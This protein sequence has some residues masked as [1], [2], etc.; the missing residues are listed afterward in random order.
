MTSLT[1][2][3][4]SARTASSSVTPAPEA[5]V[6]R[7]LATTLPPPPATIPERLR[8]CTEEDVGV[9]V[10]P[11]A[12]IL[13]TSMRDL[14]ASLGPGQLGTRHCRLG[15]GSPLSDSKEESANVSVEVAADPSFSHSFW[16]V[17]YVGVIYYAAS[18]EDYLIPTESDSHHPLRDRRPRSG[19]RP[20]TLL[21]LARHWLGPLLC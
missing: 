11:R 19:T 9:S 8:V 4:F 12:S 7:H 18:A 17:T 16:K 15:Q 5:Y 3:S 2:S 14:Q 1:T 6:M 13:R 10:P 20:G 21:L